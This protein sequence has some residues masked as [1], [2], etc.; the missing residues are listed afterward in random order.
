MERRHILSKNTN[1]KWLAQV[2]D[3]DNAISA[4]KHNLSTLSLFSQ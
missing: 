4:S 2:G 1:S 3:T